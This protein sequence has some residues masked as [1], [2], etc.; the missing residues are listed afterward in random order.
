MQALQAASIDNKTV[1]W[2]IISMLLPWLILYI[3]HI[4]VR[5]SIDTNISSE[6]DADKYMWIPAVDLKPEAVAMVRQF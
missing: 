3:S 6:Q 4:A 5:A 2:K 1:C